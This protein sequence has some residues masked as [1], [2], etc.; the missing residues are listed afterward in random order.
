M[1]ELE[2]HLKRTLEER[3]LTLQSVDLAAF[4]NPEEGGELLDEIAE[5]EDL[6]RRG[7]KPGREDIQS[8]LNRLRSSGLAT[9]EM[10]ERALLLFDGGTNEAFFNVMKDIG[11]ASRRRLEARV[12]GP[13]GAAGP[14][15]STPR[16]PPSPV[17]VR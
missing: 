8:L 14:S 12:V 6:I 11:T 13:V 4:N 16:S 10:A 15:G 1:R 7:V 3:G 9:P 2:P 17:P 5:A